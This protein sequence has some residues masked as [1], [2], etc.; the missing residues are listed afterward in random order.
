[1]ELTVVRSGPDHEVS[2]DV[3]QP[4]PNTPCV[5]RNDL[6]AGRSGN[7]LTIGLYVDDGVEQLVLEFSQA[8]LSVGPVCRRLTIDRTRYEG[9]LELAVKL[10]S[11]GELDHVGCPFGACV[12]TTNC[13]VN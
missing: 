4:A 6:F 7:E 3:C 8:G 12:V 10:D 5:T 2:L 11:A 13:D 1:V 9:V